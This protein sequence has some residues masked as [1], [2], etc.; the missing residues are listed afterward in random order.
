[1]VPERRGWY[2]QYE[3]AVSLSNYCVYLVRKTLVP[4]NRLVAWKVLDEVIEEINH[5]TICRPNRNGVPRELQLQDVY[6]CLMETV[7]TEQPSC[8]KKPDHYPDDD[9]DVESVTTTQGDHQVEEDDD[10]D[11]GLDIGCS[12]TRMG[13][14]LGKKLTGAYPGDAAGL[15]RDLATFWTGFLLHLAANTGAATHGKHLAGD[16][17]LITHL[18]ALLTH[19]GFRGNAIHGE[20]GL[21]EEDIPDID[22]VTTNS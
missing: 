17:E 16:T 2:E 22:H 13:A 19:A 4:G 1:M 10:D 15:W 6:Y 9:V 5:V 12:L 20:E 18:W 14:V 8:K 21:D 7:N 3:A 11:H